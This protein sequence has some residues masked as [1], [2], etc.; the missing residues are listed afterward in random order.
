MKFHKDTIKLADEIISSYV[1]YDK[2]NAPYLFLHRI[3]ESTLFE[4]I[5]S[6]LKHNPEYAQECTSIDNPSYEKSMLPALQKHLSDISD[7]DLKIEFI[8]IWQSGIY[9]YCEKIME[10][11]LLDRFDLYT[12]DD[13]SCAA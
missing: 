5:S 2:S 11:L 8:S 7:K 6:I 10:E 4:L 1:S 9:H 12:Q 3:S 13:P